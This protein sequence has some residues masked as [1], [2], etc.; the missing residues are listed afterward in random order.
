MIDISTVIKET[1]SIATYQ[2]FENLFRTKFEN[3]FSLQKTGK[4]K[5]SKS[6]FDPELQQL[7]DKKKKT[8]RNIL[9]CTKK[10]FNEEINI[11]FK[12]LGLQSTPFHETNQKQD[13]TFFLLMTN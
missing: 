7:L 2:V 8:E 9:D 4:N 3:F 13:P 5:S 6:W 11:Y 12:T 10:A 1:N